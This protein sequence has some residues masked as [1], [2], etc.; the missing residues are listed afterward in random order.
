MFVCK[1]KKP[2]TLVNNSK[3]SLISLRKL[4]QQLTYIKHNEIFLF[5]EDNSLNKIK[6][7]NYINPSLHFTH[8][9]NRDYLDLN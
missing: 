1:V 3:S 6:K 9:P 8:K 2:M 5:I 4:S 7:P